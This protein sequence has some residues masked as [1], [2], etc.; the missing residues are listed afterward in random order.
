MAI[1][2]FRIGTITFRLGSSRHVTCNVIYGQYLYYIATHDDE[3]LKTIAFPIAFEACTYLGQRVKKESDD[4]YHFRGVIPADEFPFP[5]QVDDNAFT[6]LYVAQCMEIV[7]G[8]ARQLGQ[9]YPSHWDEIPS[10]MFYNFD[11][12]NQRIIE[13]TGYHGQDIKQADTDLLTF[14]LEYPL[15]EEVKRNNILYYFTKLPQNHIMM[16]AAIFASI[17]C[18]L[19]MHEKVWDYF[20]DQFAHFHKENFYIASESPIN[21]CWPFLT[22]LGGFLSSLY[23]G[24]GG[25]R[26]RERRITFVSLYCR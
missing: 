25:I 14:P 9:E 5:N 4:K 23:Y 26:L 22:G 1:D 11:E 8:W 21:H 6:N 15:P 20:S 10:N 7:I 16:G 19:G 2:I 18:E 17:A 13:F 24:F 3:Y 12:G